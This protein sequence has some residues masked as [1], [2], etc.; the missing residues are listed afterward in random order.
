MFFDLRAAPLNVM[1]LDSE[2]CLLI[3]R[4][5]EP[6]P[7]NTASK[8]L[9]KQNSHGQSALVPVRI[10]RRFGDAPNVTCLKFMLCYRASLSQGSRV[11]DRLSCQF[12]LAPC[13]WRNFKI[14]ALREMSWPVWVGGMPVLYSRSLC[15]FRRFF[16]ISSLIKADCCVLLICSRS[17]ALHK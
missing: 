9:T 11:P 16:K 10:P 1:R 8:A 4:P 14:K 6:G 5:S 12:I 15:G 13:A 7:V 3:A 2:P 17:S